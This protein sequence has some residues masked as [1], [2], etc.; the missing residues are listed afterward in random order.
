M[1]MPNELR[2][3]QHLH[4]QAL[5]R[6]NAASRFQKINQQY[7]KAD[8][9]LKDELKNIVLKKLSET[10]K[11]ALILVDIQNDFV[12]Q[13]FALYAPGGEHTLFRNMALLDAVSEL[14]IDYP[15]LGHH[16]EIITTQDAHVFQRTLDNIDAQIMLKSYGKMHTQKTLNIEHN[17]LLP[18]NPLKGQYGFHCLNGTIGAAISQPIEERLKNLKE[19]IP[20]YRFAK[21]NF[22]A[23]EAGMKLKEEIELSDPHFL[24]TGNPIYDECAL[25]FLQFFHNQGYSELMLTGICGNICVQQAAEGLVAA[26][27]KVCILDPCVHYLIIPGMNSYDEVWTAVQQAYAEQGIPSI[28]LPHFRSNP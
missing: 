7:D 19:N 17:E 12:L 11:L 18:F 27:E 28:E 3:T 2:L 21:I 10:K 6:Q 16:L 25:T 13:G 23:P 26:G 9:R 15:M 8:P 1:N 22:S 20:I 24:N 5:L 14:I 4:A